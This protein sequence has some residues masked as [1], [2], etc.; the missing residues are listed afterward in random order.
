MNSDNDQP[1]CIDMDLP[2]HLQ[3]GSL[4]TAMKWDLWQ[5]DGGPIVLSVGFVDSAS[6]IPNFTNCCDLVKRFAPIWSD[7]AY[8]RFVFCDEIGRDPAD[9]DIRITFSQPGNW[10]VYGKQAKNVPTPDPTMCLGSL[11]TPLHEHEYRRIVL[12]EF[13]HALGLVHEHQNPNITYTDENGVER[14]GIPWDKQAVYDF[15]LQ[16]YGWEQE[17][18][19][20]NVFERYD[21]NILKATAFDPK[22][23]MI[24]T[25][26]GKFTG[27]RFEVDWNNELSEMDK[28]FIATLY[29]RP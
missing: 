7:Y 2:A 22:S 19:N 3:Y 20:S 13:G 5:G 8:V 21:A 17:K 9:A 1:I 24:Y 11:L 27:G 16:E 29:P 26:Q 14:E 23:V 25:I 15:Y 12:H 6:A 10:S 28:A 18:V 4:G